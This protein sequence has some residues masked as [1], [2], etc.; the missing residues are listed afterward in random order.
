[1]K[2][3]LPLLIIITLL[4]GCQL[5]GSTVPDETAE[6]TEPTM[7]DIQMSTRVA[8]ILTS[9]PTPTEL[10]EVEEKEVEV[11]TATLLATEIEATSAEPTS[12][13]PAEEEAPTP[14]PK[15][16]EETE[17]PPEPTE[18]QTPSP[19]ITETPT[20][21]PTAFPDGD[22]RN[23]LG[24]ANW[25]DDLST[26]GNWSIDEDSFSIG[27]IENGSMVMTGKQK[28]M[29]S[30]RLAGTSSLTDV[31]IE[32]H[33]KTQTC[34]AKDSYGLFFRVPN[35]RENY[36]GYLYGITCDGNYYLRK[37]DYTTNSTT[38]LV[39]YTSSDAI[40]S[41]SDQSN[42]MGIMAVG[43]RLMFYINGTSVGEY[44]DTSFT[45]GYFG[46]FVQPMSTVPLTIQLDEISYW[47]NPTISTAAIATPVPTA[48]ATP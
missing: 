48:T 22:P 28:S 45:N 25:K 19:T 36:Q 17:A 13:L 6:V 46:L 20:P 29:S 40:N 4:A 30:W 8:Q 35:I 10:V 26:G 7:T 43:N 41:G 33:L 24:D 11:P 32:A 39:D 21:A 37:Y 12:T 2:K 23:S 47:T 3:I 15:A 38:V 1:M 42:R 16:V 44:T 34:T 9:M 14:E 31:Y 18:T 5:P 27:K